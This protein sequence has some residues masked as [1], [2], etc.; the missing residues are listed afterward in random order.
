M[1]A[2]L[3]GAVFR[4]EAA[5]P[6]VIPWGSACRIETNRFVIFRMYRSLCCLSE[7]SVTFGNLIR[8]YLSCRFGVALILLFIFNY[9]FS[10]DLFFFFDIFFCGVFVLN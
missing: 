7:F 1:C 10:F 4:Y 9:V 8:S 3:E 2:N 6:I 5:L